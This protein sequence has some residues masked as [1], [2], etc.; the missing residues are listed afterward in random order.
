MAAA[1]IIIYLVIH[2]KQV[3]VNAEAAPTNKFARWLLGPSG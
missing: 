2:S 1:I 3:I